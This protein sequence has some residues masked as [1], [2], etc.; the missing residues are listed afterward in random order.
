MAKLKDGILGALLGKIG[1]VVVSKRG[2]TV[3]VKS[4]PAQ[5]RH[6]NT[7]KQ[8]AAKRSFGAA[9][10]LSS[11]LLPFVKHSIFVDEGKSAYHR[12]L[13]LNKNNAL[14][15]SNGGFEVDYS[16]L[17][18][19]KGALEGLQ[20]AEAKRTGE[21]HIHFTWSDNSRVNNANGDDQVLLFAAVPDKDEIVYRINGACRMDEEAILNIP[22]DLKAD[23]LYVYIVVQSREKQVTANSEF[24]GM[25]G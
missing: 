3:Y 6:P 14:I 25:F 18:L 7:E 5:V 22:E 19:S 16:K 11:F 21:G 23:P 1:P 12:C 8:L 20:N 17:I 4:R 9:A 13:S 2:N 24:L 15:E 10:S